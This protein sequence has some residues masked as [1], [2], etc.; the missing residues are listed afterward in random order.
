MQ[1]AVGLI[2]QIYPVQMDGLQV[3]EAW[4]FLAFSSAAAQGSAGLCPGREHRAE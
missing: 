2:V 3:Q 4:P 1:T